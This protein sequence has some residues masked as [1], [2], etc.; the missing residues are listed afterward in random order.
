MERYYL[1]PSERQNQKGFG[2]NA[3]VEAREGGT[4]VLFSYLRKIAK[5]VPDGKGSGVLVRL[6]GHGKEEYH[7]KMKSLNDS[8]TV[9]RHLVAFCVSNGLEPITKKAWNEMPCMKD[10]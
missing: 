7:G 5:I 3:V 10:R 4:L 6:C 1:L 2:R 8:P 9:M